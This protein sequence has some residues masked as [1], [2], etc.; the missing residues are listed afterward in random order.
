[1]RVSGRAQPTPRRAERSQRPTPWKHPE[2][3]PQTSSAHLMSQGGPCTQ[4]DEDLMTIRSENGS[5]RPTPAAPSRSR[6]R[7]KVIAPEAPSH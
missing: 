6:E 4:S 7:E 3:R 5:S 1:M 2:K